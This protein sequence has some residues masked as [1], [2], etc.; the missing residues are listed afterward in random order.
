MFKYRKLVL[1]LLLLAAAAAAAAASAGQ[2]R[3]A[4]EEVEVPPAHRAA[5]PPPTAAGPPGG[6]LVGVPPSYPLFYQA[7]WLPFGRYSASIPIVP[8]LAAL[9]RATTP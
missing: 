8:P 7:A 1:R 4:A 6:P 3:D 5:P 9:T 2:I